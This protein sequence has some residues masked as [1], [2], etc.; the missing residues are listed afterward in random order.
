MKTWLVIACMTVVTGSTTEFSPQVQELM[1][2]AERFRGLSELFDNSKVRIKQW[3]LQGGERLPSVEVYQITNGKNWKIIYVHYDPL[4]KLFSDAQMY[5]QRVNKWILTKGQRIEFWEKTRNFMIHTT[6]ALPSTALEL[7]EHL[8]KTFTTSALIRPHLDRYLDI[9]APDE[10]VVYRCKWKDLMLPEA[11]LQKG[12]DV[13]GSDLK[14]G[15]NELHLQRQI[16][17]GLK[18]DIWLNRQSG[19]VLTRRELSFPKGQSIVFEFDDFRP[20][21]GDYWLPFICRWKGKYGY[22]IEE[23]VLELSLNHVSEKDFDFE[24]SPGSKITNQLSGK[25]TYTLGGESV[26]TGLIERAKYVYSL[27][28]L[29]KNK[30]AK[31]W[32]NGWFIV[33]SLVFLTVTVAVMSLS[34]AHK[35]VFRKSP[36]A[37]FTLIELL[38]VIFIIGILTALLLPAVQQA[39]EASRRTQC[40]NN[41]KQI[42]L[43][44]LQY[45]SHHDQFPTGRLQRGTAVDAY[46]RSVFVAIL[47]FLDATNIYNSVNFQLWSTDLANITVDLSRPNIYLC[48]SDSGAS[49]FVSGGPNSRFPYLDPVGGYYPIALTSYGVLYGTLDLAWEIR[50]NTAYDPLGQINGTFNDLPVIR[51]ASL[52][53]GLSNTGI[54]GERAVGVLNRSRLLPIGN[55]THT[56]GI[57]SIFLYAQ[58][59]PNAIYRS[60]LKTVSPGSAI[61][62]GLFSQHPGGVNLLFG[63]GSVRFIKETISSWPIDDDRGMPVGSLTT[64]DGLL[65]LPPSGLWQALITRSGNEIISNEY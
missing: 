17:P 26:L 36:R 50:P 61:T 53:D 4:T 23:E 25:T 39:R 41:L 8:T 27:P 11:F 6:P 62:S 34:T 46:C 2:V 65:N 31:R 10:P 30:L 58:Y 35:A 44:I 33:L 63:D 28:K 51:L 7:S 37:G 60:K 22:T 38:V 48:P 32:F 3:T 52:T 19:Y 49:D 57:H 9:Y 59:S 1:I 42:G 14:L 43:G 5:D 24:I 56:I 47:P 12:W 21:S 13:S 55:W 29:S 45:E 64:A 54:T 15:K 18:D 40:I 20:V 16:T